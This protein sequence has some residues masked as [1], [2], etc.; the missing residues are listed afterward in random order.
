MSFPACSGRGR[1]GGGWRPLERT[2]RGRGGGVDEGESDLASRRLWPLVVASDAPGT[3]G[4]LSKRGFSSG[5]GGRVLGRKCLDPVALGSAHGA[6]GRTVVLL[7]TGW[8]A[9]DSACFGRYGTGTSGTGTGL[10]GA[11]SP[12]G[13]VRLWISMDAGRSSR[14]S[15]RRFSAYIAKLRSLIHALRRIFR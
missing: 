14:S 4:A 3:A 12:L 6:I 13:A 10:L 5:R 2:C 11:E 9:I 1:K 15:A 7:G 8:K